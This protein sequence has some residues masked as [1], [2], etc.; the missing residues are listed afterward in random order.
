MDGG[1]NMDITIT[2]IELAI[3]AG[4]CVNAIA[5]VS[6]YTRKWKHQAQK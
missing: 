6:Y 4:V 1:K 3:L 2:Q 5:N